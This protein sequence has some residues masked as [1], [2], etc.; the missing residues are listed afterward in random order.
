MITE[1]EIEAYAV[2]IAESADEAHDANGNVFPAL[3]EPR[4]GDLSDAEID[5]VMHRAA[6]IVQER[7]ARARFDHEHDDIPF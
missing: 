2:Q 4:I 7:A 3:I 6:E 5:M 1:A